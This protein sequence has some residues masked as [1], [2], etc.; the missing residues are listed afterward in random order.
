M[1]VLILLAVSFILLLVKSKFDAK[2]EFKGRGGS[3]SN[4]FDKDSTISLSNFADS[5]DND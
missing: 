5:Y 2:S 3:D 1:E 4:L